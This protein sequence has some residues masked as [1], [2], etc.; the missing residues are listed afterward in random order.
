LRTPLALFSL[1]LLGCG[2]D[3]GDFIQ[4]AD[5]EPCLSN[6]PICQQTAG[7]A[8]GEN[9]Y[10][11]G[12]FPGYLSFVVTTPADTTVV[13]K[14]FFKSRVHPGQDTEII[15]YEPGCSDSYSY[16][17]EGED[18]FALAGSKRVFSQEQNLRRAGDH[19]VE[20]SSDA[21]THYFLRVELKTPLP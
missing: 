17:S 8:L 10:T 21:F 16:R 4:G 2:V 5:Y 7:C 11:E 20:V 1:L 13:V 6:L 14:I 15:W 12:D 18:I 9:K 19:L 3:E